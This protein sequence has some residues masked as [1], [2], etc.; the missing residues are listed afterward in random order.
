LQAPTIQQIEEEAEEEMVVDVPKDVF[1]GAIFAALATAHVAA[2]SP[3]LT[4]MAGFLAVYAVKSPGLGGDVARLMG[5][6]TNSIGYLVA[7]IAMS[8]VDSGVSSLPDPVEN[9]VRSISKAVGGAMNAAKEGV[10]ENGLIQKAVAEAAPTIQ[11]QLSRALEA[12]GKALASSAKASDQYLLAPA[13]VLEDRKDRIEVESFPDSTELLD[14]AAAVSANAILQAVTEENQARANNYLHSNTGGEEIDRRW[15]V[16]MSETKE[17]KVDTG[18]PATNF[19][20]D[21]LVRQFLQPRSVDI[22]E[23]EAKRSNRLKSMRQKMLEISIAEKNDSLSR[24]QQREKRHRFTK[25][26]TFSQQAV[27]A[28]SKAA[29][30]SRSTNELLSNLQLIS[31]KP[32]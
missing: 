1:D 24:S 22:S 25:I 8:T 30:D 18:V 32:S 7:V 28:A 20:R 31:H 19:Q 26:E 23:V 12:I 10:Q 17:E 16:A 29:L 9:G 27:D 14:A 3:I 5:S 13:S 11:S 2:H 15:E 21:L 6:A 4:A